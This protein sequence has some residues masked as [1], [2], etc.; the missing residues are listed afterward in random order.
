MS[1]N[2]FRYLATVAALTFAAAGLAAEFE[3]IPPEQAGLSS[4]RLAYLDRS[5]ASY[6]DEG[7]LA[8]QVTLVL[9]DGQVVYSSAKGWRDKEA[10]EAMTMDTIFRIASQTKAIVSAGIMILHERGALNI[11]DPLSRYL[12]E[13]TEVQVALADGEGG[14][15]LEPAKQPITLRQLLTHTSGIGYGYGPAQALWEQAGIQGWYFADR[16]EPIAETVARMAALPIDARPGEQWVYGYSS[17]IL[18]A[19]IEKASGTDLASFLR[20]EILVPLDMRDTHFYLPRDK[21]GRLAVV[22]QPGADGVEPIPEMVGMQAQGQYVVGDGPNVSF[23]G[24]AGL[25]STARD[26]ARFLQMFLNGGE[27]DGQ[28]IL[29]PKAVELMT[30][31]H[32]GDIPFQAGSGFGLGFSV[33]TNLG[34]RGV[35]GS[36]GEFRWGGAYHTDYWVDPE[37][38][39][40]VV[41]M[42]QLRPTNG[43]DDYGRLRSGIYQAIV[44]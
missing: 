10:G 20:Q 26:Y 43:L 40:V 29:S 7:Y 17:D 33:V 9:R 23:S 34:E 16:E 15:T 6:V 18:G 27:L 3:V 11:T 21:A 19:V 42:T 5:L 12:P 25:L 30:V 24:G 39:L 44:D 2:R 1:M 37:E 38:R 32:L 8:G 22:Y 36:V 13:W 4:E 31:D 28:R 41:Y 35:M 14:Y